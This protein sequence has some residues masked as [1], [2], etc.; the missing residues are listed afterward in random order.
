LPKG[1]KQ[2]VNQ[3]VC[4]GEARGRCLQEVAAF[5]GASFH[6]WRTLFPSAAGKTRL[7]R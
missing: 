6:L 5:H 7:D 4:G 3:V 1:L 2:F